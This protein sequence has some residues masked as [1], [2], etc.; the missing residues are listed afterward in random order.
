MI[1]RIVS[2]ALYQPLFIV[3]GTI[4][5]VGAGRAFS[6]GVDLKSLAGREIINGSVGEILDLRQR[7]AG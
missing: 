3:L 1:R 7:H 4:L 2:F 5:F 6:A